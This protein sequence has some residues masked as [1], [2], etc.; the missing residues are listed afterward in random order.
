[1][2]YFATRVM[3]TFC[4]LLLD[5]ADVCMLIVSPN[6]LVQGFDDKG[7]GLDVLKGPLELGHGLA[8]NKHLGKSQSCT[9]GE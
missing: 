9:R 8:Y 6:A 4:S 3:P 2:K 5:S 7:A 1:V